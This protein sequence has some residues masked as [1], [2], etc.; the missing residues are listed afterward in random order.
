MCPVLLN[1]FMYVI[2]FNFLPHGYV[3][4]FHFRSRKTEAQNI[5]H[6]HIASKFQDGDSHSS[7][8]GDSN[9][10][11]RESFKGSGERF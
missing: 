3:Y 5:S 6:D 9:S 1:P 8:S 2:S 10:L 7:M 11:T 4:H